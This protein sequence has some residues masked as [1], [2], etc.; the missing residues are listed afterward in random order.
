MIDD[1]RQQCRR[2]SSRTAAGKYRPYLDVADRRLFL[3]LE[4]HGACMI[5]EAET[6]VR[7]RRHAE[8]LRLMSKDSKDA[9]MRLALVTLA[10]DFDRMTEGMEAAGG[11]TI[12]NLGRQ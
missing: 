2:G 11:R 12:L 8:A 3:P 10:D 9:P 4:P 7:Y 5:D 1:L 6:T